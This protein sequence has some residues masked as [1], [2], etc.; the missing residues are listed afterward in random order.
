[1]APQSRSYAVQVDVSNGNVEAA[2]SQLRRKCFEADLPKETR[3]RAHHLSPSDKKFIKQRA[4]F[5]RAMGR[6]INQRTAW[7]TKRKLI[8]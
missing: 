5:N 6:V 4:S 2:L 7:L 3:K 8:K 1:M